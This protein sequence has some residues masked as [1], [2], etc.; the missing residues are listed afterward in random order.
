MWLNKE[1]AEGWNLQ[2]EP[3]RMWFPSIETMD[4][5]VGKTHQEVLV[6]RGSEVL[7]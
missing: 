2:T 5:L 3:G 7:P 4:K 1:S 6:I